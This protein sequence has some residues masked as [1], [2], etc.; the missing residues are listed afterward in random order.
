VIHLKV[1]LGERHDLEATAAVRAVIG[2]ASLRLDANEAWD[3]A[4]AI[5]MIRKL[6]QFDPAF[7]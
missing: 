3:V 2:D 6:E 1:G 5:R 7:A 4:T